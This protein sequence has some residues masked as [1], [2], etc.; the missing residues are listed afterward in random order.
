VETQKV[1]QNLFTGPF[2]GDFVDIYHKEFELG[3]VL[4]KEI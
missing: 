3:V 4:G 1:K 2:L